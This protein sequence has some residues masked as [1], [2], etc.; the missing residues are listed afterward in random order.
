M[1][2]RKLLILFTVLVVL[3]ASSLP[4]MA[5]KVNYES[6]GRRD[7]FVPLVGIDR[8]AV[9]RLEDVT[10]V[11]DIRLEGIAVGGKGKR[12]AIL[13]GEV[14]Q[15]GDEV[16]FIALEEVGDKYIVISIDGNIH[17]LY[18]PGEEGRRP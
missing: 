14:L 18:L 1:K 7:P 15:E 9:T 13:N 4:V 12:S 2:K 11:A 5:E 17:E 3:A 6:K 16:G 10:S 8:P